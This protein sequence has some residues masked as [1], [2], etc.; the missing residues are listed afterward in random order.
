MNYPD[1]ASTSQR[2]TAKTIRYTQHLKTIIVVTI[3]IEVILNCF[4]L[5]TAVDFPWQLTEG[6]YILTHH[7]LATTVLHSYG[8]PSPLFANEYILYETCIAIIY[9]ILGPVGLIALFGLISLLIYGPCLFSFYIARDR[10][11]LG[12]IILFC[13][14]QLLINLRI[15]A[16]PELLAYPCFVALG[17]ILIRH[18]L[19]S[20]TAKETGALG[21]LFFIW[22]N[23]HGSFL[24]GL[25]M[26]GLWFCQ[27]TL[28]QWKTLAQNRD[29]TALR[30]ILA[31]F[32]GCALNPYG[33]FRFLQPFQLHGL[34]WG[35]ATSL[36]MWPV[37][38]GMEWLPLSCTFAAITILLIGKAATRP[39]WLI[40]TALVLQYLTFNSNRY[41]VFVALVLLIA[42][43]QLTASVSPPLPR[44]SLALLWSTGRLIIHILFAGFVFF[45]IGFIGFAK[46]QAMHSH[47]K[48]AAPNTWLATNSSFFWLMQRPTEDYFTLSNLTVGSWAQMPDVNN[49]HPFIDS[50]THR[51]SDRVNQLY[52]YAF[53]QPDTFRLILT[54]LKINAIIVG[55]SNCYWASVLNRAPEWKLVQIESDSQLYFRRSPVDTSANDELFSSWEMSLRSGNSHY[56]DVSAEELMRGLGRRPDAVSLQMLQET[57]DV[58]W[59][60]DPQ[61]TYLRAWLEQ[62]PD[63]LVSNALGEMADKAGSSATGVRILFNLRLKQFQQAA[64]VARDWHPSFFESGSE[65]MQ[66]L[67]VEAFISAGDQASAQ[68][69]LDH[70]WPQ[71]RYSLRW[72]KLCQ[73]VYS[74]NQS[75]M[76]HTARLLCDLAQTPAW[77]DD[78]LAALN[79]NILRSTAKHP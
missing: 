21:L 16:R 11:F 20:W 4:N 76:P 69:I 67:R 57:G 17:M 37:T 77:Q 6:E 73:A 39:Y 24:I 51:F 9:N 27:L 19:S 61:I 52:Y 54:K 79:G 41:E 58:S 59:M 55:P 72:A 23:A 42:I 12:L 36:E 50:G 5:I 31:A 44:S 35:Q 49:I 29:D 18:G 45:I 7:H 78:T 14:S 28:L 71:P 64:T 25:G 70:L 15:S 43:P 40:A 38:P 53:F 13:L 47:F 8:E 63:N 68:T 10:L 32:I 22:A 34:L 2:L 30:P 26:L 75:N 46:K 56:G 66:E 48:Y 3:I 1:G 33:I 62:V 65:D 60:F 74:D